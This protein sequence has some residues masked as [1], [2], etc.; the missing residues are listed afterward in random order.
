M[1]YEVLRNKNVF[2]TGASG[3]VGRQIATS[4]AKRGCNLFLTGQDLDRLS[5]V[6][7]ELKEYGTEVFYLTGDLSDKRHVQEL[8]LEATNR[9]G[10]VD[11]LV[12]CAGVFYTKPLVE[13]TL[14]DVDECFNVNVIAPFLLTKGFVNQMLQREWGRIVNIGSSSSYDGFANTSAY[15]SSKHALLGLSRSTN[16]ELKHKNIRTFCFS[17]GSIKTKMGKQVQNQDFDTF[18]D[19]KEVAEYVV[20]ATSFDSEMISDEI[21]MKRVNIS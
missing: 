11:I 13:T 7:N 10:H 12:N 9:L 5:L 19:P 6:A 18:I 14:E 1:N 3:G 17:P 16:S 8:I 2:V 21:I 20:F 15:C 4:Y